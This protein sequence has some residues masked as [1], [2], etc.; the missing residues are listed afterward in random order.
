M[1]YTQQRTLLE[2]TYASPISDG[3]E[4]ASVKRFGCRPM[5]TATPCTGAGVRKAPGKETAGRGT[6]ERAAGATV[7]RRVQ[8]TVEACGNERAEAP[9]L[10]RSLGE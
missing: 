3:L 2:A 6:Y 7:Q 1:E 4:S 5:T 9:A 8:P 10:S